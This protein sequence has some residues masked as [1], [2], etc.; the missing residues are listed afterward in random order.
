[1]Q[2]QLKSQLLSSAVSWA[3][4]ESMAASQGLWK[5]LDYPVAKSLLRM[6]ILSLM[7]SLTKDGA[8]A[9]GDRSSHISN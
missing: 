2:K 7:V 1:M 9:G 3:Q 8:H 5:E 6:Q 4:H